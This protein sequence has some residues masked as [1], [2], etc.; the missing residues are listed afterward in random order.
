MPR[1]HWVV[2]GSAVKRANVCVCRI[3]GPSRVDGLLGRGT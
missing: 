2:D 1:L 3:V